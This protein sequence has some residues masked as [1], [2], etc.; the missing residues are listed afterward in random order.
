MVA[1]VQCKEP[2]HP[3]L[4]THDSSFIAIIES[5]FPLLQSSQAACEFSRTVSP[6]RD[7]GTMWSTIN[8]TLCFCGLRPQILHVRL[9]LSKTL[10]RKR[11]PA[12]R[13][14]STS[15]II[16]G[17]ATASGGGDGCSTAVGPGRSTSSTLTH[18][19]R[20]SH[21]RPF[22]SELAGGP[23]SCI[24]LNISPS[25]NLILRSSYRDTQ[26]RPF[27]WLLPTS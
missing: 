13:R 16:A 7:D 9:S 17:V 8:T 12:T 4:A 19:Y 23:I 21:S 27:R 11:G 24:L 26:I 10:K 6:P 3:T 5:D 18:K 1:L 22:N 2:L 25:P 14:L 20:Y 15:I